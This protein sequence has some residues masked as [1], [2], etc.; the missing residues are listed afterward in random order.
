MP[1]Q[2]ALVIIVCILVIVIVI[3]LQRAT[4]ADVSRQWGNAGYRK[5]IPTLLEVPI[6]MKN[7]EVRGVYITWMKLALLTRTGLEELFSLLL[8]RHPG[9]VRVPGT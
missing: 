6:F 8:P 1:R 9:L 2:S 5:Y 3:V 7:R 4:L